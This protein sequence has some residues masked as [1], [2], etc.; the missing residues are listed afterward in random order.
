MHI[1]SRVG[2][3]LVVLVIVAAN[4]LRFYQLERVP[5]GA[6]VDEM[7]AMVSVECLVTQGTDAW[8]RPFP[9]FA[10]EESGPKPPT[11]IYPAAA[12][13]MFFGSS[14]GSFRAFMATVFLLVLAGLFLL[15]RSFYGRSYGLWVV[16]AAS[17]SPWT[18]NFSRIIYESPMALVYLVWGMVFLFLARNYW[19]FFLAGVFLSGAMYSYPPLRLQIFLSLVPLLALRQ[20]RGGLSFGQ[21]VVLLSGL[22]VAGLPLIIKIINGQLM[23]RFWELS[24]FSKAYLE[25]TG[26]SFLPLAFLAEF[27]RNFA[28]HFRPDYLF[29]SGDQNLVH[30]TGRFGLLSW[31]DIPGLV[32]L[33][34]LAA[35][36]SGFRRL[37][38]GLSRQDFLFAGTLLLCWGLAIVPAALTHEGLPHSLRSLGGAPFAVLLT[39][40]GLW[41]AARVFPFV[42]LAGSLLSA[43]YFTA[44]FRT[45]FYDYPQKSQ[46]WFNAMVF[47][48][49]RGSKLKDEWLPFLAMY[50]HRD[51]TIQY[52]LMKE[53][54]MSCRKAR[55]LW[56]GLIPLWQSFEG[57]SRTKI[58]VDFPETG[59]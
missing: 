24:I 58:P 7:S 33:L 38:P 26:V 28:A 4:L 22:L 2:V 17:I 16:L 49:A 39:G 54:G 46:G 55:E 1:F 42:W 13:V 48:Q 29:W 37:V 51:V 45:Y 15:G 30:A 47:E 23:S 9:L 18:W 35:G 20:S 14:V 50:R 25:S 12:W 41:K 5:A 6:Q 34:F 40:F 43:L 44:L 52:F 36:G 53:Q 21:G 19:L 57:I 3:A 56:Q 10:T 31:I 32:Y 59:R 11:Y 27:I 8:L